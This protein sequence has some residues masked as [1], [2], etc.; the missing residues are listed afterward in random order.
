MIISLDAEKAI[1]ALLHAKRVRVI[2]ETSPMEKNSKSN[3][4][5]TCNEHQ[6]KYK[7]T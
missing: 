1:P 3:G 2:R 4:Q 7:E 6:A 5:Q